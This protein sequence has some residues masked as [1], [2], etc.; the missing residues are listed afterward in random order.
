MF[1]ISNDYFIDG[2]HI[3]EHIHSIDYYH[4]ED[5]H[6]HKHEYR[7]HERKK[8]I[9]ASAI[10]GSIFIVEV[11]GGFITNSL[12]LISDAGHMLTHLFALLVSLFALFFAAKPPTEKK[13]LWLL[14]FR[15]ISS[16]V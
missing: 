1:R 7:A 9:L 11:I 3:I 13:D 8:L 10:T 14:P 12:A 4:I 6:G 15:N 16:L 2:R 5:E